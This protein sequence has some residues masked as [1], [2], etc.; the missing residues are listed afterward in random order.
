MTKQVD[1]RRAS[2]R[3]IWKTPA[4]VTY[5]VW[6]N[7]GKA[8]DLTLRVEERVAFEQKLVAAGFIFNEDVT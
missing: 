2:F 6:I 3:I 7:G 5:A 4:H 8:G 1:I